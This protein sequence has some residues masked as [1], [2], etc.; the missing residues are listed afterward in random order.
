MS[1][2]DWIGLGAAVA[3]LA[4]VVFAF[5]QGMQATSNSDGESPPN[6]GS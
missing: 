6:S 1:A 5:Q 3:F 2:M 4:L